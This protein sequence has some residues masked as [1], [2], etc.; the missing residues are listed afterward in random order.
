MHLAERL[1]REINPDVAVRSLQVGLVTPSA[2]KAVQSADWVFGCFDD[3]GPRFILNELCIAYNKPY[4]DLASDIPQ[5]GEYGGRLCVVRD[6]A[7]CLVCQDQIDLDD[8]HRYLSSDAELLARDAIY[9][10]PR[11]A[12][13][14]KG[15]SVAPLNGIIASLAVMEFVLA[16]TGLAEPRPGLNYVGHA[17]RLTIP[18]PRSD[19]QY[20]STRGFGEAANV[21]R[22]LKLIHLA[23]PSP[24]TTEHQ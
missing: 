4:L 8:V 14:D 18:R 20:C 6:G 2:F 11:D 22:Y 16:V 23:N 1:V 7:G 19:C 15:P 12:L 3:D 17:A 5:P 9:G 24:R 10:V 13:A 21:E